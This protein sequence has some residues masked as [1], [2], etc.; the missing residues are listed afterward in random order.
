MN[1]FLGC[2]MLIVFS[3]FSSYLYS[4]IAIIVHKENKVSINSGDLKKIFLSKRNTFP[5]SNEVVVVINH[6]RDSELRTKFDEIVLGKNPSQSVAYW[7]KLVFSGKGNPPKEVDTDADV[8]S[9]VAKNPSLIGY[10]ELINV[11]DDVHVAAVF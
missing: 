3:I 1:K 11:T 4:E 6:K 5:E 9:L 2:L 7:S 10:I 8:I